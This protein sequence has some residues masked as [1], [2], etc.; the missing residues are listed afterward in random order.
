MKPILK[1]KEV[2]VD[3]LL[4]TASADIKLISLAKDTGG[5]SFF[6]SGNALSTSLT[7][8]LSKTISQ[9]NSGQKD[10]LVQILSESFTVAG[11]GGSFQGSIYIDSTIGN[12]TRFLFTWS[13]G[14]ITVTLTAPDNVTIT[15]DSVSGVLSIDINGTTQVGKWLYTVTSSGSGNAVVQ[16]QVSSRPSSNAAPIVLSASVSS[17]T[18]DIADPSLSRIAIYGEVSQ[19]YTPVVGAT[20]MAY[21]DTSSGSTQIPLLDNGA[22]AD[23]TKND[24]IYSAYFLK[25]EGNVEHSVRVVVKGEEGVS[26]KSVVGGQMLP[27]ITNTTAANAA[28]LEVVYTPIEPFERSD[29]GGLFTVKN[30]PTS[31]PGSEPPDLYPPGR[32]YDL[33]MV[34]VNTDDKTVTLSWTATGDDLDQGN[35]SSY[36]IRYSTSVSQLRLNFNNTY[37]LLDKDLIQGKLDAP[38]PAG[39]REIFRVQFNQTVN[40]NITY[41]IALLASDDKNQIGQVSNIVSVS[42]VYSYPLPP[43]EPVTS[44]AATTKAAT[45]TAVYT[46][47]PNTTPLYTT[48]TSASPTN[49]DSS[50][51]SSVQQ[52][53]IGS[54]SAAVALLIIVVI[55][56]AFI[57]WPDIKKPKGG[58]FPNPRDDGV[59]DRHNIHGSHPVNPYEFRNYWHLPHEDKTKQPY[60]HQ[61][62]QDKVKSDF[63]SA[64]ASYPQPNRSGYPFPDG[65]K[66]I[67][68]NDYTPGQFKE[69]VKQT[70]VP[71]QHGYY[72]FRNDPELWN[73]NV[74]TMAKGNT[75]VNLAVDQT[76]PPY[77]LSMDATEHGTPGVRRSGEYNRYAPVEQ[78]GIAS[79]SKPYWKADY[80]DG[81]NRNPQHPERKKATLNLG[82]ATAMIPGYEEN[83]YTTNNLRRTNLQPTPHNA[84]SFVNIVEPLHSGFSNQNYQPTGY[85]PGVSQYGNGDSQDWRGVREP[86][87]STSTRNNA[88]PIVDRTTKPRMV[89]PQVTLKMPLTHL[90]GRNY[91]Y[92][93]ENEAPW[94]SIYK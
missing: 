2:L 39:A 57:V 69:D 71:R 9:R 88:P 17:D 5:L 11:G 43:T 54:A 21:V 70:E 29:S 46:T 22:G 35:A 83:I 64:L 7:D 94:Y 48:T 82:A 85:T 45:T 81:W 53:A 79:E 56:A 66:R 59:Q 62:K 92:M 30:F 44:T 87:A 50:R 4:F 1:Q 74:S 42:F 80:Q 90:T 61:A 91:P 51:V 49:T 72:N 73:Q 78:A 38:L 67:V 20:V 19:G 3:T 18:V 89:V 41:F 32:I 63:G 26:V 8:S 31:T 14:S 27:I 15:Q 25:F 12:N 34:A 52:I 55:A 77:S 40:S 58:H 86:Q 24:G 65:P 28:K 47:Q 76:R 68:S 16:V 6:E 75:Y 93:E 36:I 13:T 60:V 37:K 23:N 84:S 10:V 33:A